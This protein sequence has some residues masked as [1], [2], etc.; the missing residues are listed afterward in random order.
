[1]KIKVKKS[2]DY[3]KGWND[4]LKDLHSYLMKPYQTE[5]DW[6]D[7]IRLLKKLRCQ[8]K[9]FRRRENEKNRFV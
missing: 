9:N 8:R 7:S 4:A 3:Y 6:E 5:F 1:M 2:Y